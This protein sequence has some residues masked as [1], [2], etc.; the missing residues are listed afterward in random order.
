MVGLRF[1][2]SPVRTPLAFSVSLPLSLP[3]LTASRT[4][5]SI[6]RWLV[7]P[8]T[9]R[10][11]RISMLNVS[12]FMGRLRCAGCSDNSPAV[13]RGPS[14]Q[15]L[16]SA[17]GQSHTGAK[18]APR[19]RHEAQRRPGPRVR[20]AGLSV[21]AQRLFEG[22]DGPPQRRGAGPPGPGP[23]GGGPREGHDRPPPG[24]LRPDL[25]SGVFDPG[26][27]PA[28]GRAGHAAPRLRQALHAPVQN[29]RQG[30]VRR[31]GVAM[32]PGLRNLVRGR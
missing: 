28:P 27:P 13:R 11:L 17:P 24:V 19:E 16:Y 6:S 26:A 1:T 20:G 29:Q 25:E 8:T 18:I 21:P 7:T 14:I 22:G 12:S 31:S 2:P 30:G 4:A 15:A 9:F 3:A 10:N 23:A 5:S 32:A